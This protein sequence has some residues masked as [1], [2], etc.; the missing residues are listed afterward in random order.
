MTKKFRHTFYTLLPQYTFEVEGRHIFIACGGFFLRK[1]RDTE[2]CG[3]SD[4][5]VVF[6][7]SDAPA[8]FGEFHRDELKGR[9]L[10]HDAD[11]DVIGR[12]V[13]S[14]PFHDLH[15]VVTA[16]REDKMTYQRTFHETA[17]AVVSQLSRLAYH[18]KDCFGGV[19]KVVG[20]I[21]VPRGD[22]GREVFYVGHI[23]VNETF[24]HFQS[25]YKL[26]AARIVHNGYRELWAHSFEGGDDIGDEVRRG[27]EF[28]IVSAFV[29][30][31]E[32]DISETAAAYLRAEEF[33]AYSV[34]LAVDAV[35]TAP[36]EKDCA[37]AVIIGYAG[38]FPFV[39]GGFGADGHSSHTAEAL[40]GVSVGTA[41][42]GAKTAGGI[43][44]RHSIS[45]LHFFRN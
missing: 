11:E 16:V 41:S 4:H 37:C 24:E 25:A 10:V 19:L 30:Q 42:A 18:L 3:F 6:H 28:D 21:G 15:A 45:P 5:A 12:G 23:D 40:G 33:G 22:L 7:F 38:L 36:A 32:E 13:L 17:H 35:E 14:Y 43:F 44:G 31:F 34:I 39:E 8:E 9:I 29:L 1:S 20:S 2:L 26:V 27:N